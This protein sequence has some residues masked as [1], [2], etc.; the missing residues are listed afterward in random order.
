MKFL[1]FALATGSMSA[2]S[3]QALA[4]TT[5]G[6]ADATGAAAQNND[7]L[8]EIV[9]TAQKRSE[10]L[11]RV[12][13]SI[14]A[15][16]GETVERYGFGTL[17]QL[18]TTIPNLSISTSGIANRVAI[19]GIS[20]GDNKGFE[21][22]VA[23][24][25][26]GIYYG[27]DQLIRLPLVDV[28][29]IEVLRGP[30]PTLFGKNAIAGA[31]SIISRKPTNNVEGS[32]TGL[33]EFNHNETQLTA[34]LS[35][36]LSHSL[37]ARV[38]GYYRHLGGFMYNTKLNREEPN[39]DTYFGRAT[40]QFDN[41]GPLTG[42]LKFEYAD[43]NTLG[44][45]RENF[46]PQ[47]TYSQVFTGPLA[48]E[49][50]LDW[51]RED[52]SS[53]ATKVQNATLNLNYAFGDHTLTSVSGYLHY[54]SKD[55][56]DVDWTG[57][58]LL[59]GT[60]QTENYSQYSQEF[61]I[62]SPNNGAFKYIAGAYFQSS[63]LDYTDHVIYNPFFRT[64]GGP[65]A[66]IAD[67]SNDRVFWQKST[68]WSAFAQGTLSLTD[69][70]RVTA[71][72]RFNSEHKSGYRQLVINAG[73]TNTGVNVPLPADAVYASGNNLLLK[74]FEG[75]KIINHT[76]SDAFT[77]NAWTPMVNV[78]YDVTP[79][80]MAYAT[81]A[82]GVKAGGFDVRSNSLPTTPNIPGAFRFLPEKADNFEVG[83]KFKNREIA[84]N[85][86]YYHT[87]Y[88]D[89]QTNLF[90]GTLSFNVRNASAVRVQGVEADT[91]IRLNRYLEFSGALAYLDFQFTDFPLG[92]CAWNGT[93]TTAGGFCNYAGKTTSMA[94]KWKG[95]A[96]L[97]A[98]Y[99]ISD[100]SQVTFNV[101]GDFSSR[102]AWGNVLDSFA[103]QDGYVKLN[104]KLG[105]GAIDHSW[106]IALVGRNLTNRRIAISGG[107]LPL[108]TT[109]T[110]GRGT[111][112]QASFE[113]PRTIAIQVTK[114]F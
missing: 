5:T 18:A 44:A 93:P 70:L 22:S 71:G 46:G 95:T 34:V 26:D 94:P 19:R 60:N 30:Q 84:F 17:D 83:L 91:R 103:W 36:P 25:V 80:L 13:I 98:N 90:D 33:Y 107:T 97:D 64:L 7:G 1:A 67:S 47:G 55:V 29:R 65:F 23:Q 77:E 16:S 10:G 111:A 8:N 12:P 39:N 4:Q 72:L 79:Q 73:P 99:P 24:F 105:L 113:R 104:A 68:L 59:D 92:S 9:V 38:V 106:D 40:L 63:R 21:Q 81:Y 15:V 110:G 86:G 108:S 114:R 48:V 61:R 31:I 75:L 2:L 3:G 85:I 37:Q 42:D 102:Y 32:V 89:L 82:R 74:V 41:D 101:E 49:T 96:S 69:Q 62:T 56:N 51:R 87:T 45:A 28:E 57:L 20:S 50:N 78:Q 14:A 52:N 88:K 112:Y 58:P 27:R 54:S 6:P 66:S 35:G 43:F 76:I 11:S 109:L 53:S 100:T